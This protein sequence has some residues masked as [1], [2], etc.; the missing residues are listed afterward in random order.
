[1]EEKENFGLTY[2]LI[3]AEP[4]DEEEHARDLFQLADDASPLLPVILSDRAYQYG[5]TTLSTCGT[6][7]APFW[8]HDAVLYV[9]ADARIYALISSTLSP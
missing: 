9:R 8:S 2:A 1:M 4:R 3:H 6:I 5:E 7:M